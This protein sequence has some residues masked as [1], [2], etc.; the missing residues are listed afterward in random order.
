MLRRGPTQCRRRILGNEVSTLMSSSPTLPPPS[1]SLPVLSFSSSSSLLLPVLSPQAYTAGGISIQS[2]ILLISGGSTS[3]NNTVAVAAAAY[4]LV[5]RCRNISTTC[6]AKKRNRPWNAGITEPPPPPLTSS[7][8]PPINDGSDDGKDFLPSAVVVS[9]SSS[10]RSFED[11]EKFVDSEEEG[12]EELDLE[13][14]MAELTRTRERHLADGSGDGDGGS[15]QGQTNFAKGLVNAA[16]AELASFSEDLSIAEA[17][18]EAEERMWRD[19]SVYK[20]R[21]QRIN[22]EADER[23]AARQSERLVTF[24]LGKMPSAVRASRPEKS[25]DSVRAR[26]LAAAIEQASRTLF[27][28]HVLNEPVLRHHLEIA[29]VRMTG[30]LRVARISWHATEE[31]EGEEEVKGEEGN[32]NGGEGDGTSRHRGGGGGPQRDAEIAAALERCSATFRRLLGSKV[33]M[34]YVPT[35][36]FERTDRRQREAELDHLFAQINT[37]DDQLEHHRQEEGEE[38]H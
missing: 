10:T 35:I 6:C 38:P 24:R 18:T 7:S 26:R 4:H 30:H 19:H 1:S 25:S 5:A 14:L 9:A 8:P 2:R 22:R 36:I 20:P 32:G 34:K 29:G 13:Q 12:R 28:G 37:A 15:G 27:H 21:R 33:K 3:F 11:L 16:T 17:E 23:L 31:D